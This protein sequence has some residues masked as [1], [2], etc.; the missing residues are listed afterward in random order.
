MPPHP[1][2]GFLVLEELVCGA[3]WLYIVHLIRLDSPMK[4]RPNRFSPPV[5]ARVLHLVVSSQ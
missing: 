2:G 4:A 5:Q 1:K 3:E